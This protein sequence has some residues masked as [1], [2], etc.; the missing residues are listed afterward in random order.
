MRHEIE[1]VIEYKR[2]TTVDD[3]TREQAV[4]IIEWNERGNEDLEGDETREDLLESVRGY[5]SSDYL[6]PDETS[7]Q[8]FAKIL[9][10]S[11]V[12]SSEVCERYTYSA[13]LHSGDDE[14][15]GDEVAAIEPQES[16]LDEF[17]KD[18][19]LWDKIAELCIADANERVHF[20]DMRADETLDE[21]MARLAQKYHPEELEKMAVIELTLDGLTPAAA[22]ER[23]GNAVLDLADENREDLSAAGMTEAAGDLL[24]IR[25]YAVEI[26]NRSKYII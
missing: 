2:T 6:E 9:D 25:A 17:V 22:F 15:R 26:I 24:K 23:L 20:P 8:A 1:G 4:R 19:E 5:I 21:G 7:E 11:G 12:G 18:E 3:L 10:R 14:R 13:I 16:D